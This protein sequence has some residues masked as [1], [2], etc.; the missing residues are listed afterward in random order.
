MVECCRGYITKAL[1]HYLLLD[2]QLKQA[3]RGLSISGWQHQ[4]LDAIAHLADRVEQ[5]IERDPNTEPV[6]PDDL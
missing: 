3:A 5:H 6:E 4:F 2:W 1:Q